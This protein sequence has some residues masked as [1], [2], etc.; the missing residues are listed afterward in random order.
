MRKYLLSTLA[1]TTFMLPLAAEATM[2]AQ[3]TSLL[4]N[5]QPVSSYVTLVLQRADAAMRYAASAPVTVDFAQYFDSW[6]L[7][8]GGATAS[9]LD[10]QLR[11]TEQ[12]KDLNDN[13]AC[14]HLDL[15]LLTCKMEQ[16]RSE[17]NA[18]LA[19]PSMGQI[20][21]LELLMTFLNERYKQVIRGAL[22][23]TYEDA[24]WGTVYDFDEPSG[25]IWCCSDDEDEAVCK[26]KTVG[27]CQQED[28]AAF[29]TLS[30][31]ER[32]SLCAPP[33]KPTDRACPFTSD[34][35]P[36]SR[37]GF[38]CDVSVM[39]PRIS[40]PV[41]KNQ[42]D[43]LSSLTQQLN[44]VLRQAGVTD[45]NAFLPQS[46]RVLAGCGRRYGSCSQS[47][48]LAC[49]TDEDCGAG[50]GTCEFQQPP[51]LMLRSVRGPFS[52]AKDH[53]S[54]LRMFSDMRAQQGASRLQEQEYQVND[55]LSP[56]EAKERREEGIDFDPFHTSPR[57][58]MTNFSI[59]QERASVVPFAASVDQ[60]RQ[61]LPFFSS[62][63]A[64]VQ[65]LS[66]LVSAP[67][68][69]GLRGFITGLAYF[70]RR[71]CMWRPCALRLE[72]IIKLALTDACFP[73]ANGEFL[74]DSAEYPRWQKCALEACIPIDG[75][76]LSMNPAC[77]Q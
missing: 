46:H 12:A 54:L 26:T 32:N 67:G 6:V 53:F 44:N 62:I 24:S 76:D 60:Q 36:E 42:R 8:V 38:G 69:N 57:F 16:V 11:L 72:Q 29:W 9:L 37:T 7:R 41:L 56:A 59:A 22:D 71:S 70:A 52:A 47:P 30:A 27:Q 17:L 66:T 40:D 58:S 4:E 28:A 65:K 25:T 13:T 23:P 39:D 34:Y 1:L 33:Q 48:E 3:C 63:H 21:R 68:S 2:S 77:P 45:T 75:V 74:G 19:R 55:E 61:L 15:Q 14:L 18:A 5:A 50:E 49:G 20:M 10:T 35:A 51:D 73:Y 64:A 31:C 43:A